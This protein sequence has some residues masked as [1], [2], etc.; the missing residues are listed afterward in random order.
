MNT[1]QIKSLVNGEE[2]SSIDISDRGLQF[3]D[4][5]FETVRVHQGIPVWWQQHMD[6][7]LEGCRRLNFSRLPDI[8]VL[9]N[10]ADLLLADCLTGTLKVIV[11]RGISSSGYAVPD[12][13]SPNRVLQLT[14]GARHQPKS[15]QGIVLGISEQRITGSRSM[16][17]IKHL[18]RLEQVL[19]RMECQAEGWDECIMLDNE[20]KVIEGSMSNLFAWQQGR[21]LTPQ[22]DQA[23]IK[24]ICRDRIMSLAAVNGIDVE[25]CELD[26]EDL[27]NSG[28]LFVCNSLIGI[29]PIVQFAGRTLETGINTRKLQ[30]Q[31]EAEI[32]SAE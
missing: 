29:W 25:Q 24:G 31:L 23:G 32:C 13:I 14:S 16:S 12:G 1:Q 21:L 11:T 2:S 27:H 15:E 19:A 17:G 3:G 8:G 18:N 22:L 9:R 28:G 30:V 6:R 26:L 10:E 4:G 7:L 5:V 20:E